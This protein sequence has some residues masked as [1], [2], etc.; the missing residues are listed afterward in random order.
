MALRARRRPAAALTTTTTPD[1]DAGP[2]HWRQLYD[3]DEPLP[4]EG[5]PSYRCHCTPEPGQTPEQHQA[6]HAWEW[7][8]AQARRRFHDLT[9]KSSNAPQTSEDT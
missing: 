3:P 7:R 9:A 1:E 4:P 2:S 8:I 5:L 6:V